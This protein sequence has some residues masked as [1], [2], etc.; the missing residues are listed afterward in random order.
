MAKVVG[1]D[2]KAVKRSTCKNCASIIEYTPSEVITYHGGDYSGDTYDC[3]KLM[4]P[5]CSCMM[6][7]VSK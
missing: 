4:C 2:E 7:N 6:F 3:Y 1:R 5:N